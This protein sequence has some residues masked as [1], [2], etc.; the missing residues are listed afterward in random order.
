MFA[1]ST[2]HLTLSM[3]LYLMQW[4]Y[5]CAT[6]FPETPLAR[7]YRIR[8]A[9]AVLARAQYLI[10]DAVVVWR[11]WAVWYDNRWVRGSLLFSLSGTAGTCLAS[12][13][14]SVSVKRSY[15][16]LVTSIF[17]A[18]LNVLSNKSHGTHQY[19]ALEQN[20]LGTFGLLFTNFSATIA[21]A[22]KAWY[23]SFLVT[24]ALNGLIFDLPGFIDDPSNSFSIAVARRRRSKECSRSL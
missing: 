1:I 22:V 10:S 11:A 18:V 19:P 9:I 21:I 17:L 14:L 15:L 7:L 6:V 3:I 2:A 5:L 16:Q 23:V 12:Y 20:L 24:M 13:Y 8:G 4:P